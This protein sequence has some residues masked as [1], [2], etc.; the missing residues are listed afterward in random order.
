MDTNTMW[1]LGKP[2]VAGQIRTAMAGVAGS[3]VTVGAIQGNQETAFIS[4]AT[5][6]AM[7]A[8]PAAWS[9]VSKVGWARLVEVMAKAKPAVAPNATAGEAVKVA[10]EAVAEAAK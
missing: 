7:Y 4:M 1:E 9:W 6:I 8:I 10:K 5:G 3:L 2:I